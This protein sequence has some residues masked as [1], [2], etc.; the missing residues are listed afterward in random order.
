MAI[1]PNGKLVT[2]ERDPKV[3][4]SYNIN[5]IVAENIFDSGK[6]FLAYIGIAFLQTSKFI[7]RS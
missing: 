3:K 6:L 1:L 7:T 4:D 2:T 5:S